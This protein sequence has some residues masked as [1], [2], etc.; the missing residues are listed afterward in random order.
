MIDKIGDRIKKLRKENHIS[1]DELSEKINVSRQTIS[2]WEKNISLP[3]LENTKILCDFFNVS[4]EYL[5]DGIENNKIEKKSNDISLKILIFIL[6]FSII[7]IIYSIIS[8]TVFKNNGINIESANSKASIAF[9]I[10]LIVIATILIIIST[11]FIVKD[12][13]N[14]NG[15][16]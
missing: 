14:K 16:T 8:I 4:Y 5:V 10:I 7:L 12:K 15:N 1:Q 6:I 2:K 3:D 9:E 11:I 13:K